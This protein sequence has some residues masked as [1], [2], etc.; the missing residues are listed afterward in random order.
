[1]TRIRLHSAPPPPFHVSNCSGKQKLVS[2]AFSTT[3]GYA[4]SANFRLALNIY[5]EGYVVATKTGWCVNLYW[6]PAIWAEVP[7]NSYL[8]MEC[9]DVVGSW[10][11]RDIDQ[12][13]PR[14]FP[15]R[16]KINWMNGSF[17]WLN[18][19]DSSWIFCADAWTCVR[20]FLKL[21]RYGFLV[22][23]LYLLFPFWRRM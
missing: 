14:H 19:W 10:C 9:A 2:S 8:T 22:A 15:V 3:A 11:A 23:P 13:I 5:I 17:Y 18:I 1:M 20:V 12:C 21:H 6:V 7:P 16:R 4:C